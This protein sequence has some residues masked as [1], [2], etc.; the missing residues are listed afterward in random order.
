MNY[1]IDL[2]DQSHLMSW[3]VNCQPVWFQL[4]LLIL[5]CVHFHVMS[6]IL[7][8]L[9]VQ[10]QLMCLSVNGLPVTV[11]HSSAHCGGLLFCSSCLL[12]RSGGPQLRLFFHGGLQLHLLCC[13]GLLYGSGGHRLR[14]CSLNIQLRLGSLLCPGSL[15]LSGTLLCP[16]FLATL[17]P[18][19]TLA[20][21]SAGSTLAPCSR[22]RPGCLLHWL[23]PLWLQFLMDLA[24]HPSY[25][26]STFLLDSCLFLLRSVWK[27]SVAI[28]H[29][30]AH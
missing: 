7:N 9:S 23:R 14:P 26:C 15:L 28:T 18:C 1:L 27:R 25:L 24:I 13:G 17:A 22:L 16:G 30:S 5:N 12:L 10:F 29:W 2:S 19:P 3:S 11:V 4:R 8:H 21:C 20:L 6:L